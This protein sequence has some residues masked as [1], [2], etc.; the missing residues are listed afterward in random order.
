MTSPAQQRGCVSFA[1]QKT[2]GFGAE[3]YQFNMF[4]FRQLSIGIPL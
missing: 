1:Q 3:L 2:I 4:C